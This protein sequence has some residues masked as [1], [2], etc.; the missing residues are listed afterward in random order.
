MVCNDRFF[1]TLNIVMMPDHRRDPKEVAV[2]EEKKLAR[3]LDWFQAGYALAFFAMSNCLTLLWGRLWWLL[4]PVLGVLAIN[5]LAGFRCMPTQSLWRKL[6]CH[7]TV[8]LAAFYGSMAASFLVHGLMLFGVIPCQTK[9]LIY[10]AV[11]CF[12]CHFVLFLNGI[13]CV[14]LTSSQ[15]GIKLRVVGALCGLI[16]V[17]NLVVLAL[18]IRTTDLEV[19]LETCR[20]HRNRDRKDQALC[21]TRYPILLVHGVFFRDNPVVKYWGRIPRE[22]E[23]N[24][25]QVFYGH[26][27]S[28]L[29]V[30]DSAREITE[31]IDKILRATGCEKVNIIA[32]SKGGLDCRYAMAH[33]GAADKVASLT[34]INTPHRG[35]L[36]ADW[37]LEK[38]SQEF[39]ESVAYTYNSSAKL[40]G[41]TTPD[42]LAAVY[43]LTASACTAFD[44]ATPQ[45]EGVLCQSVGSLMGKARLGQFPLN[46]FYPFVKRFDG[47]NDGL[48]GE[49]SFA[50][51]DSYTLLRPRGKRGISHADMTDLNR[52]NIPGFD[53]REFYVQLVAKLKEKGL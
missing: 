9:A 18:I 4:L 15:L 16:P 39:E 40:L 19:V 5:A 17:V 42:F 3:R 20:E 21:A 48:V 10:S 29:S 36:F 32:H 2:V 49:A 26:H 28:A 41:D 22:L 24:G 6:C 14:Y 8:L 11:Y 31:T 50:W 35:C 51:G 52:H 13:L 37:L 7:G 12:V 43:D 23:N 1:D 44:R 47:E 25:A 46:L 38:T 30:A 34:T 45:P 27:Q 33:C 53:V